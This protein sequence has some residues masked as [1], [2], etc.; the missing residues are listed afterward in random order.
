MQYEWLNIQKIFFVAK[1]NAGKRLEGIWQ[2]INSRNKN[3]IW[4]LIISAAIFAAVL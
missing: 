2:D 3:F 4:S 1:I